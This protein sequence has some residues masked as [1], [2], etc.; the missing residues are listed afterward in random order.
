[1][2][3]KANFYAYKES[4]YCNFEIDIKIRKEMYM[5]TTVN[6]LLWGSDSWAL[7]EIHLNKLSSFHNRCT[8]AICRCS[9]DLVQERHQDDRV[10]PT[11]EHARHGSTR[12]DP[13][14]ALPH[15]SSEDGRITTYTSSD[16]LTRRQNKRYKRQRE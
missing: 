13:T 8:R 10:T 4:L 16:E 5:A 9:M 3:A 2:A 12:Y 7:S 1:M 6:I 14:T 11:I 15:S